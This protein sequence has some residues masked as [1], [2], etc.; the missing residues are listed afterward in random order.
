LSR[1]AAHPIRSRALGKKKKEESRKR[2]KDFAE[3]AILTEHSQSP[4]PTANYHGRGAP[5]GYK[6]KSHAFP[7]V[8]QW[9]EFPLFCSPQRNDKIISGATAILVHEN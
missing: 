4:P 3:P 5:T 6:S 8:L 2:W 1:E 9:A 7:Q